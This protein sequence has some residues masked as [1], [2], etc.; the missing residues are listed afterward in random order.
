MEVEVT[1]LTKRGSAVMR[2]SRRVDFQR[3]RFGLRFGRGTENEVQLPDIR[4]DLIAAALFPRSGK[5]SIQALGPSPLRVNGRNTRAAIVGLDDE[6]LIGP[7]RVQ[8]TEPP[9]GCDA[10][11][12]VELVQPLH[13]ALA[14][15]LS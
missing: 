15:L 9:P 1:F 10:A 4:V 7:Y 12:V 2:Q 3:L 14:R 13:D 8:L 5:F 11:F 6:I